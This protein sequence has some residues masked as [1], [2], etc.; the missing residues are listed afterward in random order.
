MKVHSMIIIIFFII[1]FYTVI[2]KIKHWVAMLTLLS[3]WE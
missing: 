2:L 3:I 1:L